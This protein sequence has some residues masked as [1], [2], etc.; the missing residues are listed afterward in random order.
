MLGSLTDVSARPVSPV[1][2]T[3]ELRVIYANVRGSSFLWNISTS[4]RL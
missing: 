4:S 3:D 1:V 2:G